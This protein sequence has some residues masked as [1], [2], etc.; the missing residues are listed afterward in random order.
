MR[1]IIAYRLKRKNARRRMYSKF[2]AVDVSDAIH[3]F[4]S[5]IRYRKK[6]EDTS[7]QVWELLTG[8]WKHMCFWCDACE[9]PT[10][11]C[12]AVQCRHY[13]KEFEG[14]GEKNEGLS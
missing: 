10:I 11:G 14:I 3:Q 12:Q 2:D 6:T 7:K 13:N 9:K 4:E 8:D 1:Y 5:Y